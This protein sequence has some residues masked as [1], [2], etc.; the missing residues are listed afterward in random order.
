MINP[1]F[2]NNPMKGPMGIGGNELPGIFNHKPKI[3]PRMMITP[4]RANQ[5]AYPKV[6]DIEGA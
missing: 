1:I 5:V 4:S 6:Q 3:D 2:I